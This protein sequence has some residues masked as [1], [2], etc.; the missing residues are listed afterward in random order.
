MKLIH[1][2]DLHLGKNLHGFSLI[3]NKDQPYWVE[4]FLRLAEEEKPDAVL[5]AGDV[6]DRGAPANQAVELLDRFLTGLSDLQIPV[7]MVSGNH[8]S[9]TKLAF[10]NKMLESS[11]LYIAG[12]VSS[13][14][15]RVRLTDA[16]G[17]VDF[18]LLPYV[19][20]ALVADALGDETIRDYD[21]ALRRLLEAQNID[22]SGRN[23]L[24]AHQNVMAN[25]TAA[26]RGGSETMVG[27]VGEIDYTAFDGFDYVALGHIHA[28][29]AM[30]RPAVRYAGSPLCYHFSE[31]RNPNKGPVIVTLGEKGTAPEITTKLLPPLHPLREITGNFGEILRSE[32][33]NTSG[34]EYLRVVLTDDHVPVDAGAQL[35][36]VFEAKGS[37]LMELTR[38]LSARTADGSPAVAEGAVEKPV[39]ELF[40]DF[41]QD[42]TAGELPDGAQWELLCFAAEQLRN[43]SEDSAKAWDADLD[44]LIQFALGQ[45]G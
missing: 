34:G 35:K 2:A 4:Q 24:I 31:L 39:E 21:T 7:L 33:E 25:G 36:A 10:A 14:V 9:G 12:S 8:D 5:I 23:V 20:P 45:E 32:M 40:R 22:F 13:G 17:P 29:Q 18:W 15:K 6:Y 11:G 1:I 37:R 28:A 44:A 42:R 43:S 38:E 41:Y 16:Y 26:Q 30:G 27:G 3:E 19:F